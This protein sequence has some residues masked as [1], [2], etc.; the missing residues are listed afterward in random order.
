MLVV[1]LHTGD[2]P[3]LIADGDKLA[4]ATDF[5][6]LNL[7]AIAAKFLATSCAAIP[8]LLSYACGCGRFIS[9]DDYAASGCLHRATFSFPA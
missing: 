2:L 7:A 4:S 5:P 8:T 6:L 3:P 9:I 1:P